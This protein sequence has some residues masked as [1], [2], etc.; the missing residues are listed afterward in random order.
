MGFGLIGGSASRQPDLMHRL[1]LTEGAV[2][3][4]FVVGPRLHRGGMALIHAVTHP[5]HP[6]PLVMKVPALFEGEDP[7]AIVSFEM[8]QMILPRLHGPHAPRFI[9]NG[10][11]SAQPFIV[12][13]RIP[14]G[15]LLPRLAHLPMAAE[16]LAPL[17]ALVATALEAIHRQ[18]VVHLDVKPSNILLRESGEAVLIDYGLSHHD[19]LPDL[20]EEEFRLP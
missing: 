13:E 15:S 2:I 20:M 10:D 18:H 19:Q 14:A 9:A 11:F 7:A 5:D 8:E 3:G 16:E 1:R 17:G 4:G 6:G 12:M